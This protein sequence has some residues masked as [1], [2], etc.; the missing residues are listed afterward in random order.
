MTVEIETLEVQL[1][2]K[3]YTIKTAGFKISRP[4]KKRLLTE[5]KPIMEQVSGLRDFKFE[6]PADLLQLFVVAEDVFCDSFDTLF[7]MLCDYSADLAADREY[8]E[9]HAT[10]KQIWSAF[11]GVVVLA[12]PFGV[13]RLM[14]RQFGLVMSGT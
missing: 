5:V 7:D 11:Q 9:A 6:T 2:E 1:G 10:D 13:V 4:W 8:L 12:D 3:E 14:M